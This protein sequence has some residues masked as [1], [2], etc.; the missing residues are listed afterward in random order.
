M[1]INIKKIK[2]FKAFCGLDMI[3]MD[4]FEHYNIIFGNNGCGKTSLTRA[5][6]LLISK[7]KHIEKYRTISTAESPSIEFECKD[8]SY[9]IEPNSNIG[10]P[11]FKVEIYNSDFLHNNTPFNSEF[12]LKKLDDG[13]IILEGSVLGEETK[14]INQL[15]DCKGKV[16]KR[17][18]EI[19][20][21]NSAE[22]LIAKQESE[23]KKYNEEII[24]NT[25][26]S[27]F[28]NYSNNTK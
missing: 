18:K 27:D 22:T 13:T 23:I 16:E 8:E 26:K 10:V 7:N 14:E 4:E 28:K 20:D 2:F 1:A 12:G 24:K 5:F 21:E 9:T 17:Q 25:R 6:E 11:S 19:G 15:K 3:E